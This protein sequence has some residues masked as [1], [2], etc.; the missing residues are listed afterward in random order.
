[1]KKEQDEINFWQSTTDILSALLLVIILVSVVLILYMMG[2]PK[3]DW[4]QDPGASPTPTPAAT[5]YNGAGQTDDIHDHGDDHGGGGGVP[6]ETPWMTLSPSPTVMATPSPTPF[7]PIYSGGGGGNGGDLPSGSGEEE[8]KAAVYVIAVDEETD[9]VIPQE[10]LIFRLLSSDK[11]QQTL[12]T[13]YPVRQWFREFTTTEDGVFYLPEKIP[14][15]DYWFTTDDAPR[16]YDVPDDIFFSLEEPYDWPAPYVVRVPFAPSKNVIRLNMTDA[17]TGVG[18]A[19][20]SFSV[21]AEEDV[22]TDDGTLRYK[23]GEQADLIVCNEEGYGESI[24]L[25]LGSYR[26]EQEAVPEYYTGIRD[27]IPVEVSKKIRGKEVEPLPLSARRT[28]I[29]LTARDQLYPARTL[30]DARFEVAAGRPGGEVTETVT[31]A[32]G[33]II[34]TDLE[35]DTVYSIRQTAAPGDYRFSG[36]EIRVA[37][38]EYGWIGEEERALVTVDNYMIRVSVSATGVILKSNISDISMGLYDENGTQI[39]LWSSQANATTLTALKPG[40]YR[41]VLN[42]S[43][44]ET[45]LIAVND[46]PEFQYYSFKIW[47]RTDIAIVAGAV[48]LIIGAA[49]A[50][51]MIHKH[52]KRRR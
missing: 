43:T 2:T 37:V 39:S 9:K 24:E 47:T 49:A 25:Y 17:E 5:P 26:L 14:V 44:P 52:R 41:L 21:I 12:N 4:R 23:K 36:D 34:L 13:Y 40:Q 3:E 50:G 29:I 22:M 32:D 11:I 28:A 7:I 38:D 27:P 20:A 46:T 16:G 1:M 33:Q 19:G 48:L 51:I 18:L 6:S 15:K 45:K 10:G 42:G 30:A 31:D 35:K 8:G